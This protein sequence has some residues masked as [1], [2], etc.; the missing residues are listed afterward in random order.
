[1]GR[2]MLTIF[3]LTIAGAVFIAVFNVRA[4][5]N[6]VM[7]QVMQHFL[8]DVTL[9]FSH[10]YRTDQIERVLKVNVPGVM[11]VE[12]WGGTKG[13][14]KDENDS[15]VANLSIS[16]PPQDTQLLHTEFVAGRWLLPNEHKAI[17]ISD[18]IYK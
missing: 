8:G 17:V 16:A 18:S 2:L 10:P 4:T 5:M 3:T 7:D 9:T 13:E 6:N 14:I 1:M 11:G 12:G 15:L